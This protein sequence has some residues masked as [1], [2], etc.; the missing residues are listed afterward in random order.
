MLTVYK[1]ILLIW[2]VFK[3]CSTFTTNLN[4]HYNNTRGNLKKIKYQHN[5]EIYKNLATWVTICHKLY[6]VADYLKKPKLIT[7]CSK[8]NYILNQSFTLL[9]SLS[10]LSIRLE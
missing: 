3:Y 6:L 8:K 2:L 1:L 5:L 7:I 4:V 10:L 9:N